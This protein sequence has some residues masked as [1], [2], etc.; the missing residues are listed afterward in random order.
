MMKGSFSRCVIRRSVSAVSLPICCCFLELP[1]QKGNG[2]SLLTFV[3]LCTTSSI[4]G[5]REASG[6]TQRAA[7]WAICFKA[8]VLSGAAI[9]GSQIVK[10][11]PCLIRGS[12]QSSRLR[13]A[14]SSPVRIV[15]ELLWVDKQESNNLYREKSDKTRETRG[16]FREIGTHGNWG[17]A[18]NELQQQHAEAEDI[19]FRADVRHRL[20]RTQLRILA[21][22]PVLDSWPWSTRCLAE[23]GTTID[24]LRN[25]RQQTS[26]AFPRAFV[27]SSATDA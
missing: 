25:R 18:S 14:K 17:W 23:V 12:V 27:R 22:D 7:T 6:R 9:W 10:A 21:T 5:R 2:M 16:D 1:L 4:E 15:T 20:I 8:A 19:V 3:K 11:L 24:H 26:G 13:G